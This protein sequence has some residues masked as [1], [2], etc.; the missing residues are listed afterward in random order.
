ML[1]MQNI[2]D[3]I[4]PNYNKQEY[5]KHCLESLKKQTYPHWRCLVLDSYSNDG[6]WEII[7]EFAKE[8]VRFELY[9]IPK[10]SHTVYEAWNLGLS[11]V[12]NPYFCILTSDDLWEVEWLETAINSLTIYPNAI[13]VAARTK[14]ID[15]KGE[16]GKITDFNE[17]GEQFFQTNE[18]NSQLR[19]GIASCIAS[20]FIGPIYTSIHSL[21]M[22]SEILRQ[23]EKFAEDV[24]TAADYEWYIKLGLYGD[25]IYHPQIQ[26]GW[27]IYEGQATKHREQE[28]MGKLIKK[29]HSRTKVLIAQELDRLADEF[30]QA[31]EKY[32][33]TILT[34]HYTRPYF[35]NL[36][37]KPLEEIPR[38]F[39]II[40]TMPK[41]T[42][43]DFSYKFKRK[44]FFTESSIAI[45]KKFYQKI[46]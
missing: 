37:D 33:R 26:V 34:Y 24:G 36:R 40:Y 22:R 18:L 14:L 13:G 44:Y 27:R 42:L 3:I 8:D 25:I 32:D 29:I 15:E 12:Q 30:L 35:I 28:S 38:L 39:K 19:K 11:K 17:A 2:I 45:A 23:G 21:V 9:Q 20:F 6:S 43:M 7:K 10:V 41:E 16:W 4:L 46:S 5:I 31:A 1:N